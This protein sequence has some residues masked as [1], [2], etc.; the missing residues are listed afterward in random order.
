MARAAARAPYEKAFL[1]FSY[2]FRPGRSQHDALDALATGILRRPLK[3]DGPY[4]RFDGAADAVSH[5]QH[6]LT[7]WTGGLMTATFATV[8]MRHNDLGDA[9]GELL[10]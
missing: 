6:P 10:A 7:P 3:L 2:G 4:H 8:D 5:S 1:G 9:P